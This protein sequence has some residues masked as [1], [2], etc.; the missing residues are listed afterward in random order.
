MSEPKEVVLMVDGK[1]IANTTSY[2]FKPTIMKKLN[3]IQQM[4]LLY[5]SLFNRSMHHEYKHNVAR[6]KDKLNAYK[7][8]I[9]FPPVL[10][11]PQQIKPGNFLFYKSE[12]VRVYIHTKDYCHVMSDEDG[13]KSKLKWDLLRPIE[14]NAKLLFT[15]KFDCQLTVWMHSDGGYNLAFFS[16]SIKKEE[17]GWHRIL[18]NKGASPT[19]LD[20]LHHLQNDFVEVTGGPL[21][22]IL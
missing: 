11:D 2:K 19:R 20:Y 17:N 12:V 5:W 1:P 3:I 4:Q 13:T 7:L 14:L 8:A 16:D 21:E 15:F 9:S 22:S 18:N 6:G 10:V